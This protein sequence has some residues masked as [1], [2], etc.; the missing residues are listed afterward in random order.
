LQRLKK[1]YR[2]T[3]QRRYAIQIRTGSPPRPLTYLPLLLTLAL[4]R[5]RGY[6]LIDHL[7]ILKLP[8]VVY[9]LVK[10]WHRRLFPKYARKTGMGI[11]TILK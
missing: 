3:Y 11:E 8:A 10:H 5:Q 4:R 6:R 2:S 9:P 7:F 1:R